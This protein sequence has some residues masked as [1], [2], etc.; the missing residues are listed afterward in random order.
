MNELRARKSYLEKKK[1]VL[2][3]EQRP[4]VERKLSDM[5]VENRRIGEKE[6]R[7]RETN[8]QQKIS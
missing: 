7:R 8:E 1:N 4:G 5:L 6:T 3:M 2:E